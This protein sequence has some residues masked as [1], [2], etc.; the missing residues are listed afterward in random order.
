[1]NGETAPPDPETWLL[2]GISAF[3]A[4]RPPAGFDMAEKDAIIDRAVEANRRLADEIEQA[5]R[6]AIDAELGE[7]QGSPVRSA[8]ITEPS[9]VTPERKPDDYPSGPP[10]PFAPPSPVLAKWEATHVVP[11]G[12]LP[13]WREPDPALP[14][15]TNLPAQLP[16]RVMQVVTGWA[17][18]KS[19]IGRTWWVDA[20]RLEQIRGPR[21]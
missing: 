12:G 1:V 4:A 8:G 18:V 13:A 5:R 3:G 10:P 2:E 19:A 20:A 17:Q 21:D 6:R 14:P 15:T 9:S 16:V 11:S 7:G